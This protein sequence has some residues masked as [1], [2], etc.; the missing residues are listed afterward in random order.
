MTFDRSFCACATHGGRLKFSLVNNT[1]VRRIDTVVLVKFK[2]ATCIS[3]D[4]SDMKPPE[5]NIS[6]IYDVFMNE[7]IYYQNK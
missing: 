7:S 4:M 1:N 3:D 2:A 5:H 6:T